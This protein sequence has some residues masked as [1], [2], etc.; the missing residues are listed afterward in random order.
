M[1]QKSYDTYEEIRDSIRNSGKL[2]YWYDSNGNLLIV[3]SS[4][5]SSRNKLLKT[6]YDGD[7]FRLSITF[8]TGTK[9]GQGGPLAVNC[10][11]FK[12]ENGKIIKV[13]NPDK[14]GIVWF[15]KSWLESQGKW[16]ENWLNMIILKLRRK[17]N[18]K[19]GISTYPI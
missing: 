12:I 14:N 6:K 9:F 17:Y 19:F 18:F 7:L 1:S 16:K 15:R 13:K 2:I 5:K 3:D 8:H 4:K 10:K 11:T